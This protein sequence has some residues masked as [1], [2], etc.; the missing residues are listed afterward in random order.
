MAIFTKNSSYIQ[1]I[2]RKLHHNNSQNSVHSRA[3]SA[4]DPAIL[5]MCATV[6]RWPTP[7]RRTFFS[8]SS[9]SSPWPAPLLL[10]L[11]SPSSPALALQRR[12]SSLAPPQSKHTRV[13]R[14]SKHSILLW[15]Q[16]RKF[17]S[18][19]EFALHRYSILVWIQ[20]RKFTQSSAERIL[21]LLWL[22][23]QTKFC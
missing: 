21:I 22:I 11:I 17:S 9:Q 3:S 14:K 1:N 19:R 7:G 13:E 10:L 2:N 16:Q 20:Q 4:R 8:S 18:T 12:A 23:K 6:G 15:I 5:P